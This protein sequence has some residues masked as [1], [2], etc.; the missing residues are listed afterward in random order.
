MG[1]P[2]RDE[3]INKI[4]I[5]AVEK[6]GEDVITSKLVKQVGFNKY[7]DENDVVIRLADREE[8]LEN[9]EAGTGY[10]VVED[11]ETG[12]TKSLFKLT[13]HW[14]YTTD[15]SSYEFNPEVVIDE[16]GYVTEVKLPAD[17]KIAIEGLTD[18]EESSS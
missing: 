17:A 5:H 9:K 11:L 10:V 3:Y 15:G 18:E 13:K 7:K 4:T 1:R 16:E 8:V 14:A 2:L 12:D 6:E